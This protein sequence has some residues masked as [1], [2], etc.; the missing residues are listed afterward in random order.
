MNKASAFNYKAV[1]IGLAVFSIPYLTIVILGDSYK[2]GGPVGS[3]FVYQFL[4][5]IV[6]G[7][8]IG[9]LTGEGGLLNGAIVGILAVFI[10]ALGYAINMLDRSSAVQAI[11]ANGP[12]WLLQAVAG[13]VVGAFASTFLDKD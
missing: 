7:F 10:I 1:L 12:L 9:R 6:A 2:T 8:V 3:L 13:S 4:L 11:M 5:L